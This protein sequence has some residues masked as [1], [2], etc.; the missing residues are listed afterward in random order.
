MPEAM[1]VVPYQEL[2]SQV[3]SLWLLSTM[4][5]KF[6][7][8]P[9]IVIE[10]L[11]PAQPL[12]L[13][14]RTLIH[15][16]ICVSLLL[17]SV[18]VCSPGGANIA[19]II[20]HNHDQNL[21]FVM[22]FLESMVFLQ[23][24]GVR[25]LDIASRMMT[26]RECSV[27]VKVCLAS[28][29]PVITILSCIPV[30]AIVFMNETE[31]DI[32][33]C[34]LPLPT[35]VPVNW[36]HAMY[37]RKTLVV[38][39]FD[40]DVRKRPPRARAQPGAR[41][42]S[43]KPAESSSDSSSS[44][45]TEFLG[46]AFVVASD[47]LFV[48]PGS[49][50]LRRSRKPKPAAPSGVASLSGTVHVSRHLSSVRRS[51]IRER[52]VAE[53]EDWADKQDGMYVASIS[54]VR[55]G[56]EPSQMVVQSHPAIEEVAEPGARPSSK[57]P[58]ESSSD[59]SSS[60]STEFL[61]SAFV[62]ASD[63]L[64]VQP[65][66][67]T[68]RRSRKPKPAAPSGVASLSGT[69][70]VSRHLSSVRRSGIRERDV[71]EAEDW[72]D[73]QDGMYV[74]SISAVREGL[75]PS[76]MV[77]QSHPAIEEVA[78]VQQACEGQGERQ[79]ADVRPLEQETV[80]E[81][82]DIQPAIEDGGADA[83]ARKT[84]PEVDLA[85]AAS[86]EAQRQS[87]IVH[88]GQLALPQKANH[89]GEMSEKLVSQGAE[90]PGAV[91]STQLDHKAAKGA[92][93]PEAAD[94]KEKA[95]QAPSSAVSMK[96]R[97]SVEEMLMQ[98]KALPFSPSDGGLLSDL[99]IRVLGAPAAPGAVAA[100]PGQDEATGGKQV[101]NAT[102]AEKPERKG[103]L[104]QPQK[105]AEA[106]KRELSDLRSGERPSK[107]KLASPAKGTT[108][109]HR[110]PKRHKA[111]HL[112]DKVTPAGERPLAEDRGGHPRQ[113]ANRKIENAPEQ[114]HGLSE[115]LGERVEKHVPEEPGFKG[116]DTSRAPSPPPH[117]RDGARLA[118]A[119]EEKNVIDQEHGQA[120]AASKK[121][122]L[123][124][125]EM[126][127]QN[128]ALPISPTEGGILSDMYIRVS[129]APPPRGPTV[130]G[131][132]G[133]S[134]TKPPVGV[135]ELKDV[136]EKREQVPDGGQQQ[137]GLREAGDPKAKA[138]AAASSEQP[139]EV[140]PRLLSTTKNISP[141]SSKPHRAKH[142]KKRAQDKVSKN[143]WSQG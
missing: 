108:P 22:L 142:Q 76:Q 81:P 118:Q 27:F 84:A 138:L 90:S 125:Q 124:V 71:A 113:E 12:V 44:S 137:Q 82:A 135:G 67:D 110:H 83:C 34:L 13:I 50:T 97:L 143:L 26:G 28:I 5:P 39:G 8:M 68:L 19:A 130:P 92:R 69:V 117:R 31:L 132:E 36:E 11:A 2:W 15:F 114:D 93:L 96:P 30:F 23:F 64:F 56:L 18:V 43:K 77:V 14:N 94:D 66:S 112:A 49:D 75:E 42:S 100:M 109:K 59:S 120:N 9:D 7:I 1:S 123:S 21:R 60:S 45:S 105:Q 95:A 38:E 57:K 46:S 103:S 102:A 128:K 89:D 61:G 73:K 70:H 107:A 65:G 106:G 54:A 139:G 91:E 25:R 78:E 35:W 4:L 86:C 133:V 79:Y 116:A 74:A 24:C 99:H 72:A 37:Y 104:E 121:P 62:V 10:V 140:S 136:A 48:Q 126:L 3:H 87:E 33:H 134:R 52:D 17:I 51:G 58:A 85:Q 6:L 41:P 40:T 29:I 88:E 16:F 20:V 98:N 129:G 47:R 127:L 115:K 131:Q 80:P 53:A 32:D 119:A 122:R 111:K 101:V 55:E 141:V 63:R